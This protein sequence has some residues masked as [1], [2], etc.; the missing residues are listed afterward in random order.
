MD[1]VGEVAEKYEPVNPGVI[2]REFVQN[3]FRGPGGIDYLEEGR[4]QL[5]DNLWRCTGAMALA[6][7]WLG[8]L[9][10]LR[11]RCLRI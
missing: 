10:W 3:H 2:D 8:L 1:V 4:R 9:P 11:R 7:V 6:S 5:R